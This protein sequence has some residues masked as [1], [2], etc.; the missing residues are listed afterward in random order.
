MLSNRYQLVQLYIDTRGSVEV[1]QPVDS[2]PSH[3]SFTSVSIPNSSYILHHQPTPP[4]KLLISQHHH[5]PHH[6]P[7]TTQIPLNHA[8]GIPHRPPPP[9][10]Q[11]QPGD[12]PNESIRRLGHGRIQLAVPLDLWLAGAP[13][14]LGDGVQHGGDVLAAAP[15]G[16]FFAG[17]ANGASTHIS[18]F[19]FFFFLTLLFLCK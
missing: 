13:A 12:P 10:P 14:V 19:F 17:A 6:S 5:H 3:P 18:V 9:R 2:Y 16:G 1:I 7:P 8:L 4:N 11:H 15:P